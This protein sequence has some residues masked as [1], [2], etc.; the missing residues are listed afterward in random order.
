[1][2]KLWKNKI[3][4]F[5]TNRVG[6]FLKLLFFCSEQYEDGELFVKFESTSMFIF[7]FLRL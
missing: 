2:K 1:M 6:S 7:F 5:Y 3:L 4:Y